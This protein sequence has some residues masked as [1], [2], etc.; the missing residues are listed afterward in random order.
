MAVIVLN[1]NG[2]EETIECLESVFQNDYPD[3]YP[4]VVDNGST[5]QSIEKIRE[6]CNGKI[7]S[8]SQYVHPKEHDR[9]VNL[10]EFYS[11]D[12]HNDSLDLHSDNQSLILI[13]NR[14]N[15]GYAGGNNIGITYCLETL[16]PEFILLLNND[17]VIPEHC[18]HDL[19]RYAEKNANIGMVQPT[20][21]F[22]DTQLI[23]NSG[24]SLDIWGGAYPLKR[25]Q[26]YGTMSDI[27]SPGFFYASGACLMVRSK[28][29]RELDDPGL[30]ATFF[31]YYEDVDLSWRIRL[32]G[33][34][35]GICPDAI[36][37]HKE[38]NSCAKLKDK[39]FFYRN[40]NRI[41]LHL[42]NY[43]FFSLILFLPQAVF[44]GFISACFCCM[45][46]RT[47][48]FLRLF[49]SSCTGNIKDIPLIMKKRGLI[50]NMREINDAGII[51]MMS[52]SPHHLDYY[53]MHRES[54]E[55]G[56]S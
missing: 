24:Y 27:I 1:W 54:G 5:D 39:R 43:S 38:G 3:C 10:I 9:R 33:Y 16:N 22:Y 4:I 46:E 42:K 29:L 15:L 2:W 12:L 45:R 35:I 51:S 55:E 48:V 26:A 52:V 34:D 53:F 32:I 47:T 6:F 31:L 28:I 56:S 11:G 20:I 36:C 50:Q 13:K 17:A 49:L 25:Y 41:R 23:E 19:V 8:Y 30:D 7:S 37:Y 18:I 44:L 40:R 14:E 21:L